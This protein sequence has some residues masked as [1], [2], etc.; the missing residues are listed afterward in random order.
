MAYQDALDFI[1]EV[2]TDLT[3]AKVERLGT[4]L[5]APGSKLLADN[6]MKT[7]T[8]ILMERAEEDDEENLIESFLKE[9]MNLGFTLSFNLAAALGAVTPEEVTTLIANFNMATSIIET[10]STEEIKAATEFVQNF[11]AQNSK[12]DQLRYTL[13]IESLPVG[14][15]AIRLGSLMLAHYF[16]LPCPIEDAEEV[17]RR[18]QN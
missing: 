6:W 10:G 8:E 7:Q 17:Y 9:V 16:S 15:A 12:F 4:P 14:S 18:V 5:V 1:T 13:N 3:A 11:T 2:T